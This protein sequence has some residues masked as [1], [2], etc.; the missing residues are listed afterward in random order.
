MFSFVIPVYNA[1]LFLEQC[2]ESILSQTYENIEVIL[3]DDGSTDN[4]P[5]ICDEYE[6]Y[7]KRV[8]VIHKNNEG[9]A[10]ARNCGMQK[11]QGEWIIFVDADDWVERILCE[12]LARNDNADIDIFFW[13]YYEEAENRRKKIFNNDSQEY[14]KEYLDKQK[15]GVM[16][17]AILHKHLCKFTSVG[18]PWAKAFRRE[19]LVKNRLFFM[20]G[21]VKGEDHLFNLE[22]FEVAE[23]AAFLNAPLYHYRITAESARHKYNPHIIPIIQTQ[24]K[25]IWE[26]IK[27]CG[28]EESY[29][30]LFY[31]AVYRRFMI[32]SMINFCHRDNPK[33]F[34]LRRREYFATLKEEPFCSAVRVVKLDKKWPLKERILGTLIKMKMFGIIC[35]LYNIKNRLYKAH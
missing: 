20:P 1:G 16:Q 30:E 17:Q 8:K 2:V 29:K 28:K 27:K 10:I 13:G 15:I 21:M 33:G 25:L 23:K 4:S 18:S 34:A 24:Y 12:E 9:V 26:F 31:C 32:D 19:F 7:D 14:S 22:A 3:V 11:A 6:K 5:Q 35:I